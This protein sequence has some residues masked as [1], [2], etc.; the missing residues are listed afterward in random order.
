MTCHVRPVTG[1]CSYQGAPRCRPYPG[2]RDTNPAPKLTQ[3]PKTSINHEAVPAEG[4]AAWGSFKESGNE[5]GRGR[6]PVHREEM[7]G[8]RLHPPHSFGS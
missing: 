5:A 6:R 4:W 8:R 2:K 1:K 3:D 7:P